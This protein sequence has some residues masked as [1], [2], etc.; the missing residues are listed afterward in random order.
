M[1]S[2]AHL[3]VLPKLYY[4]RL[5]ENTLGCYDVIELDLIVNAAPVTDFVPVEYPLCD[6]D[7]DGIENFDFDW[8]H[9]DSYRYNDLLITIITTMPLMIQIR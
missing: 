6:N 2:Q 7:Q 1:H 5:E 9:N 4:A 3:L 8:F